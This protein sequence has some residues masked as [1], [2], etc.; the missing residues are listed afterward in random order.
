[1]GY[2]IV[3]LILNAGKLKK[4]M[5]VMCADCHRQLNIYYLPVD[6]QHLFG[7]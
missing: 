5:N 6:I 2:W 4:L 1:M 3:M 7:E